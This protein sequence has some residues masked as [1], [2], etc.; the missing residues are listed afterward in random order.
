VIADRI[1]ALMDKNEAAV[2][3]P[4]SSSCLRAFRDTKQSPRPDLTPTDT[5]TTKKSRWQ[6]QGVLR[7][8]G[9]RRQWIV[10]P[11]R[12]QCT[13]HRSPA[14]LGN[15][16]GGFGDVSRSESTWSGQPAMQIDGPEAK[17]P[18]R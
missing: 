15:L 3:F 14:R 1:C 2:W 12:P 8:L 13:R 4:K 10:D 7:D 17:I 6:H 5:F 11:V 9:Q 16:N 18:F